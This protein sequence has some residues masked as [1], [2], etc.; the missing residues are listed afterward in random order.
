M[1]TEIDLKSGRGWHRG[2]LE[3][4]GSEAE[5]RILLEYVPAPYVESLFWGFED[6]VS[7]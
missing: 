5:H 7:G 3:N 1:L 2:R 4:I 6:M